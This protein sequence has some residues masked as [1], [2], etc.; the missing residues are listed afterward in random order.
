MIEREIRDLLR[1]DPFV[2]FRVK[3]V[4]GDAHDISHPWLVA[5]LKDGLYVL[6][7]SGEWVIFAYERVASLESLI[8][9]PDE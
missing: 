3:L 7:A 8:E 2:P 6:Y 4:N 1:R 5:E 9:L